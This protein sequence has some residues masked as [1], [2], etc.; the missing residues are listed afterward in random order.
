MPEPLLAAPPA[1]DVRA[2][3]RPAPP[4]AGG[5]PDAAGAAVSAVSRM[6]SALVGSEILK[7]AAA[8]RA[9]RAAGATVCNLTVGDFDPAQFRVPALLEQGIVDALRAGETNYP[10]SSGIDPLRAAVSA[11]WRRRLGLEYDA[12]D[13]VV[14][15]GS[16][17]GIYGAYRTLVDAG[18]RVV[19]PVPS[20]NN[21]HYVHLVDAVGVPLACGPESGFLPTAD[22]L[23]P[24]VRDPSVRLLAVNSPLNPAGTLFTADQLGALCDVVLAENRRRAGRARPLYVLYDQV[25]WMLAFGGARHVDPVT[26]RPA[27]RDYTVYVDGISKAFAATGVRVGWVAGPGPVVRAMSDVLGHVGAWAPRAEQAATARLLA[28]DAAVDAYHDGLVG[29]VKARLDAL[30]AGFAALAAA[31]HPVRAVAP[32]GAI[33]LSVWLGLAGRRTAAGDLLEG[34][35]G[36]RRWLLDAAGLA[37]V[38]F[39]AFGTRG[40]DGWFRCSVG[41]T[42]VA[43]I[44]AVMPRLRAALDGLGG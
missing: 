17:P 6:A 44:E 29:G 38:P 22:A 43:E 20:W 13:V 28:D 8:I 2:P 18:E 32:E 31:G 40:D 25:Y 3:E 9:M 35:E 33:Y 15:G 36:V 10:P 5:A 12:A 23:A 14:T 34:D 37:I 4:D 21:N 41:A 1:A 30:H 11:F 19:Y 42:S 27:M 24:L 26:L 16:R 39:Q 7:I